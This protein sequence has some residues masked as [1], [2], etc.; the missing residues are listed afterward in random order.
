MKNK[1]ISYDLGTS[2][3]KASLYD[4]EGNCL[5]TAFVAYETTYPHVGWHEQRPLDWWNAVVEST[6][7][8]LHNRPGEND[9][10][11]C[12]G[13]SG[14]SLGV[15]PIDRK[16]RLLRAETPIWSDIRAQ[17]EV[18]EFFQ[19]VDPDEWYQITGNGFP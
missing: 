2:G 19:K 8:L 14:H 16:G 6:R 4:H 10:V 1:V 9:N 5:A 13:I 17:Q 15:I 12:I 7:Q 3:N 18:G 11:A